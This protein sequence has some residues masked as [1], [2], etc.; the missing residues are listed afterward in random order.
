MTVEKFLKN[1]ARGAET[2]IPLFKNWDEL[3][4]STRESLKSST[5]LY[6]YFFY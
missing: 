4:L 6:I 1:I 3:M 5:Y 2:T